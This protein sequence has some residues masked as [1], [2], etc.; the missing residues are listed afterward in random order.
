MTLLTGAWHRR[1]GLIDAGAIRSHV[2][3]ASR[4][5]RANM[6]HVPTEGGLEEGADLRLFPTP[7]AMKNNLP[8]LLNVPAALASKGTGDKQGG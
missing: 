1:S 7:S 6:G 8:L 2:S 5:T 4:A 3:T